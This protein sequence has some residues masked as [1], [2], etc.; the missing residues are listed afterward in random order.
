MQSK[1]WARIPLH[2]WINDYRIAGKFG[3]Q[4]IWQI[5]LKVEKIKI[6]Q[7]LNLVDSY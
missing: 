3:G 4:K 1:G 6:W 7:N 2:G 5:V